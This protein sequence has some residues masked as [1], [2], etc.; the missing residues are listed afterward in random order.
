MRSGWIVA[1]S[2]LSKNTGVAICVLIGA[3]MWT[4]NALVCLLLFKQVHNLYR[5][6]VPQHQ[7]AGE[8]A[9]AAYD[10]EAVRA[11][12][13]DSILKNAQDV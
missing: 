13:A 7:L 5:G 8:V 3:L 6:S 4:V 2:A 1:F 9:A 11:G 10:N 12:V